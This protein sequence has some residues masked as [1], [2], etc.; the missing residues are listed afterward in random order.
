MAFTN[1]DK[2]MVKVLSQDNGYSVKK[3]KLISWQA[4][5]AFSSGPAVCVWY[6]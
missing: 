2:I 5:T 1:A 4:I 3:T 6:V